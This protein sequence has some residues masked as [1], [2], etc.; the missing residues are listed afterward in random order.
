ML[1]ATLVPPGHREVTPLA[2]EFI[3]P[4]D[5]ADKQDCN[6][7]AVHRWLARHGETYSRLAPIHLGDDPFARQRA[8]EAVHAAGATSCSSASQ[9]RTNRST[10]APAAPSCTR[11]R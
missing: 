11:A 5:S 7:R 9:V 10:K 3:V 4:Q 2:R 6:Q 8:S 1:S